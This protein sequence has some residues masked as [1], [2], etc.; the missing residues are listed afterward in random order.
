MRTTTPKILLFQISSWP[1]KLY[2]TYA[3]NIS[4]EKLITSFIKAHEEALGGFDKW[5]INED[6]CHVFN[7]FRGKI[8]I[9]ESSIQ[10]FDSNKD[11]SYMKEI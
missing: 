10:L 8:T 1:L 2:K 11:Y 7:F 5:Y 9:K 6:R 3:T 4:G